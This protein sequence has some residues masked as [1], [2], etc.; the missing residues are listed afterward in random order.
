[1]RHAAGDIDRQG[2]E[3]CLHDTGGADGANGTP[4]R[5]A[6]DRHC[7]FCLAG[8]TYETRAGVSAF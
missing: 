5:P 8:V 3:R 6:T 4:E 2:F 1:L 7:I